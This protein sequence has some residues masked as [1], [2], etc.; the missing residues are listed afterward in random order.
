MLR[1]TQPGIIQTAILRVG[2]LTNEAVSC[3]NKKAKRGTGFV[4]TASFRS[5][6]ASST[7]RCGK[8]KTFHT[9]NEPCRRIMSVVRAP[10]QAGNHLALEGSRNN[11]GNGN[12]VRGRAYNVNVNAMEA[13][14]DPNVVT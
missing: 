2:I 7:P 10:G 11:Q 13:V 1:A 6:V 12:R 3:E 8:C 4:A 14:Q 9:E 5:E